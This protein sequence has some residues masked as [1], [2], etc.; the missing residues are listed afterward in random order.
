MIEAVILATI[1]P[2]I[3]LVLFALLLIFKQFFFHFIYFFLQFVINLLL[4][5]QLLFK[6]FILSP[7]FSIGVIV[8]DLA[9]VI[10]IMVLFVL[11]MQMGGV[12]DLKGSIFIA[13]PFVF[14]F[15]DFYAMP[16][17]PYFFIF[18]LS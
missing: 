7:I 13:Q 11:S 6:G 3:F 14:I 5:L 2:F 12:C 8:V 1:L 18:G 17:L 9:E 15:I 16:K 10:E 4:V